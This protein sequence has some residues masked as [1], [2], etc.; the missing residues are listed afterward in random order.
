MI[1]IEPVVVL[2]ITKYRQVCLCMQAAAHSPGRKAKMACT[3]NVE[4]A[5]AIMS[6]VETKPETDWEN[7]GEY[8]ES[9]SDDGETTVRTV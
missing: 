2:T 6:D 9:E 8:S 3:F 5:I 7:D 4:Q 1:T